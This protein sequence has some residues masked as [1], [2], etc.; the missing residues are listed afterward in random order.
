MPLPIFRHSFTVRGK[1]GGAKLV[2]ATLNISGLGQFEAHINGHNVTEAVLTP[3]WSDYRK[4]IYYDTYDVTKLVVPGENAI[5]VMLGNGMYNVESPANRYTKFRGTFGGP[6]LMVALVLRFT[7]GSEQRIISDGAWKTAAGPIKF[8]NIYGGEDYDARLEK[9]GWDAAGFDDKR[10]AAASV[11]AGPGGVLVAETIPPVV[12]NE[13]Y[14][15][16]AVTHPKPGVTVYDLG[17]NMAGWPEI[18]VSGA[19]GDV[20]KILPGELLDANGLVT[21]RSMNASAK[22]PDSFTYTLKGGGVEAWHPRFS[23]TGFR[24]VQVETAGCDA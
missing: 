23:Y 6:K 12:V 3:G 21:Q 1:T 15:P 19:R 13:S 22:D 10:W 20:V 4:R 7:D 17:Q 8:S 18:E 5:G 24:Y 9:A 14:A 11:V 16:V 2:S